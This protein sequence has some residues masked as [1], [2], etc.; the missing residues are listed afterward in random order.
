MWV[1]HAVHRLTLDASCLW[2]TTAFPALCLFSDDEQNGFV[3][4][5]LDMT[6]Q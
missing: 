4:F 6:I 5:R 2:P 1:V 3:I